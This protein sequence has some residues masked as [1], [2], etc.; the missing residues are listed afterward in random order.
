MLNKLFK[1]CFV[2]LFFVG[3]VSCNSTVNQDRVEQKK[4]VN[5]P[6][7]IQEAKK[8]LS[9]EKE[10]DRFT[11][12]ATYLPWEY[13]VAREQK[14]KLN[15]ELLDKKVNEINDLQYYTFKIEDNQDNS[16]LLMAGISSKDEYYERIQ[17]FSFS[18]QQDLKLIDGEDTL[19][20]V[21]FHFERNYGL[22]SEATFSLGFPLTK[23][24]QE[25]KNSNKDV[26]NTSK[27]LIYDDKALG[28]GKIYV[29]IDQKN[30]NKLPEIKTQ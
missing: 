17:Y 19:A 9:A 16:E 10:I 1:Y 4:I 28:V 7:E 21:L 22:S 20:C 24:E 3:S 29:K 18:M 8:L 26:M 13:I 12:T 5:T 2:L 11:F 15:K 30:L 6:E 27:V 25:E 23:I 14:G